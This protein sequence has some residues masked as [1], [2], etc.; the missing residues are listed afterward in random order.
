M[1]LF[2]TT[3][4]VYSDSSSTRKEGPVEVMKK[5]AGWV[6]PFWKN[7]GLTYRTFE[8]EPIKLVWSILQT[9]DISGSYNTILLTEQHD[10]T[11]T[12]LC[13]QE[14]HPTYL[15][16]TGELWGVFQVREL[17][18]EIW[19]RYIESALYC[20]FWW[21]SSVRYYRMFSGAMTINFG[22]RTLTRKCRHFDKLFVPGSGAFSNGN[23]ITMTI[24][25][26]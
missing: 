21:T 8:I 20:A 18:K 22:S 6:R 13:I 23:L 5:L 16:L 19:P 2:R 25:P 14:R 24:F 3:A 9:L 12:R 11:W 26:L 1:H 4:L 7:R 15:D 17:F 10:A